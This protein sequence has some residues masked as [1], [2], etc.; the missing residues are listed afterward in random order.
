MRT[1]PITASATKASITSKTPYDSKF[2]YNFESAR[3][4]NMRPIVIKNTANLSSKLY[5]LP[6]RKFDL[7]CDLNERTIKKC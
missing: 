5:R 6:K 2:G 1:F 7:L 4:K 3:V